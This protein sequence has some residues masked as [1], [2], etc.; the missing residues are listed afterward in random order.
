MQRRLRRRKVHRRAHLDPTRSF[1]AQEAEADD[2]EPTTDE[3]ERR[4]RPRTPR[5]PDANQ[6]SSMWPD[7]WAAHRC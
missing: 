3:D 2:D 6:Q 5:D 7:P 1:S 4:E